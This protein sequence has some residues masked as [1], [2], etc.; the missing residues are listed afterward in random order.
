MLDMSCQIEDLQSSYAKGTETSYGDTNTNDSL[1]EQ[2]GV[3]VKRQNG[4]AI[5]QDEINEIAAA[6]DKIQ[7]VF[8]D[9][10]DISPHYGLKISHAGEKN[11]YARKTVGIFFDAHRAIGVSFAGK[12]TD[13]LVLAHEYAHFLD[14]QAGKEHSHF[15]ASDK[16]GAAE[17]AIAKEFRCHE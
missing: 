7:P 8:G 3:L 9:L 2:Y 5:Q 1:K 14:S 13:F 11:V 10:K 6:I 12:G 15:F 4:D 17:N 16:P